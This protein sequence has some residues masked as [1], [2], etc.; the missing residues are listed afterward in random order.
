MKSKFNKLIKDNPLIEIPDI[1]DKE[2]I[3]KKSDNRIDFILG[4]V[5]DPAFLQAGISLNEEMSKEK[6]SSMLLIL[7][8]I[9]SYACFSS[10]NVHTSYYEELKLNSKCYSTEYIPTTS[11]PVM[12]YENAEATAKD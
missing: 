7:N 11:V 12:V 6:E 3:V 8:Q 1:L 5:I 2:L 9:K 4:F 10:Y